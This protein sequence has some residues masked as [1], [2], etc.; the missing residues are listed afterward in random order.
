MEMGYSKTEVQEFKNGVNIVHF[1]DLNEDERAARQEQL[2]KAAERFMKHIER[3]KGEK[4][5]WNLN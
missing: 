3:A 4:E 1:P 5:K 2:K